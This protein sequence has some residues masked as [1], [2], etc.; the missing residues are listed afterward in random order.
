[1]MA[2]VQETKVVEKYIKRGDVLQEIMCSMCSG[3]QEDLL[4]G[5]ASH[6]LLISDGFGS[7]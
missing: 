5:G 4:S 1:M 2:L 6:H 7:S 3:C